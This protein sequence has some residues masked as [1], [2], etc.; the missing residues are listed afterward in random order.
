MFDIPGLSTG[1]FHGFPSLLIQTPF[2]HAAISLFGGQLLSFV[3]SGGEEVMW[4]SPLVQPPPTAIRGGIPVCWP[5]FGRQGQRDTMPAHGFVRTVPWQQVESCQENDGSLFLVLGPPPLKHLGL[6]LRMTLRIGRTLEQEL[7]TENIS[8]APISFTQALHNYFRVSNALQVTVQGLD[9]VEYLDKFE[10][11]TQRH[12]QQGN[13]TLQDPRDPGRA[14]RIYVDTSG[15]YVLVDPLFSRRI[16]LTTEGSHSLVVWNPGHAGA[17]N[18]IDVADG[19]RDYL[20]LEP[21]N[22]GPDEIELLPGARHVLRQSIAIAP[23]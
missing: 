17:S 18:M 21:A 7:A 19:W 12:R 15:H 6:H 4:L 10:G 20:C 1:D 2:S 23:L 22:A 11:Y 5:Y 9:G 13:W 3:P 14:D 8:H 16:V